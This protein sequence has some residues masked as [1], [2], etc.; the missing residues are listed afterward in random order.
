M[1]EVARTLDGGGVAYAR[2][3]NSVDGP[4]AVLS[5]TAQEAAAILRGYQCTF[6]IASPLPSDVTHVVICTTGSAPRAL[7]V[8]E[9]LGQHHVQTPDAHVDGAASWEVL[10]GA[11]ATF[12]RPL[13]LH[14]LNDNF[15]A[16]R[17][18]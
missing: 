11:V 18:R 2:S 13:H 8:V 17:A 4:L 14:E 15:P 12:E 1:R 10:L 3:L 16:P 9:V 7:W 5:A 6:R